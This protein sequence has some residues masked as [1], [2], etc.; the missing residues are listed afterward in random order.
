[1]PYKWTLTSGNLPPGLSLQ[2]LNSGRVGYLVGKPTTVGTYNW[3]YTVTD[4]TSPDP[5]SAYNDYTMTV[6]SSLYLRGDLF[7]TFPYGALPDAIKDVPLDG[8]YRNRLY[9]EELGS[10]SST[11]TV[12]VIEGTKPAW[13][14]VAAGATTNQETT[15]GAYSKFCF[16]PINFT[17]TPTVIGAFQFKI[18]I[19]S[20]TGSFMDFPVSITV[21]EPGTTPVPVD[22]YYTLTSDKTEISEGESV[23]IELYTANYQEGA[24]IPYKISGISATDITSGSLSGNF[25]LTTKAY[26][27]PVFQTIGGILTENIVGYQEY[28]YQSGSITI[29]AAADLT[30]EGKETMRVYLPDFVQQSDPTWTTQIDIG[31][32]DTSIAAIVPTYQL[33]ASP[34]SITEGDIF[35]VTLTTTDVAEGTRFGWVATGVAAEDLGSIKLNG[36]FTIGADGTSTIIFATY[37]NTIVDPKTFKLTV[38]SLNLAATVDIADAA[39]TFAL[40]ASAD[41]VSEGQTVVFNLLTTTVSNGTEYSYKITGVSSTDID[42]P[43]TG[44]L[45][46]NDNAAGIAVK[47]LEDFETEGKETITFEIPSLGKVVRVAIRDTSVTPEPINY[48]LTLLNGAYTEILTADSVLTEG[49]KFWIQIDSSV[50]AIGS[51]IRYEITGLSPAMLDI[52]LTGSWRM[53]SREF[54]GFQSSWYITNPTTISDGGTNNLR[55]V[56]VNLP[57]IGKSAS[58]KLKSK[59]ASTT[60]VTNPPTVVTPPTTTT[61]P[62]D[63]PLVLVA[64]PSTL[65]DGVVGVNYSTSGGVAITFTFTGGTGP[66]TWAISSGSLPAGLYGYT[67]TFD[68]EGNAFYIGGAPTATG[69]STFTIRGTDQN[70]T[71]ST[72]TKSITI[73]APP[74]DGGGV[75]PGPGDTK[76]GVPGEH[77]VTPED[78]LAS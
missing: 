33:T 53:I 42:K 35:S 37:P 29:T 39:P 66:L 76:P 60:P 54:L 59:A 36:F 27:V 48:S 46:V 38:Q 62:S 22:T 31:I 11:F 14:T 68:N 3:R 19:T 71:Q 44:T 24:T 56:T 17:G 65:P 57:D 41:E 1:M 58:F 47:F 30:T 75:D 49:D 15:T 26:K 43:L 34:T 63:D 9:A 7:E 12:T 23:T 69:T 77:D 45:T 4:D 21:K 64:T 73:T 28:K 13:L 20:S 6:S 72:I 78:A 51:G 67:A 70:G 25:T 52:P 40:S 16:A 8:A 2:T 55:T 18:R 50:A 10:H 61:T 74:A 32:R 5:L